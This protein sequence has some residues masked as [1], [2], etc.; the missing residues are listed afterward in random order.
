MTR[1][2]FKLIAAELNYLYTASKH[3]AEEREAAA[4]LA[5][6][7]SLASVFEGTNSHFSR[8]R[9]LQACG[10]AEEQA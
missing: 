9:F 6:A 10:M 1:K 3:R 5:V 2:H 7:V 8:S 4:I